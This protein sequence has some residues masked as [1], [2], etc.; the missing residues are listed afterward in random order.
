MEAKTYQFKTIKEINDAMT[1]EETI[2]RFCK[3]FEGYLL[4][5]HLSMEL[6]KSLGMPLV[7]DKQL[8]QINWID[9]GK[10]E[11]HMKFSSED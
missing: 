10:N 11:M 4:M 8:H 1:N 5:N 3:D 9:D 7:S 6:M 2:K